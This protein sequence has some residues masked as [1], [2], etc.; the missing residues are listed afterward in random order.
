MK[1]RELVWYC[2]VDCVVSNHFDGFGDEWT[3]WIETGDSLGE[4]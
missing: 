4:G 1:K 2:D 3:I